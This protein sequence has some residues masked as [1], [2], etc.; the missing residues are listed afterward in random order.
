MSDC[1][2]LGIEIANLQCRTK[3]GRRKVDSSRT[4]P[5]AAESALCTVYNAALSGSIGCL[6]ACRKVRGSRSQFQSPFCG[7]SGGFL[8]FLFGNW[9]AKSEKATSKAWKTGPHLH[10]ALGPPAGASTGPLTICPGVGLQFTLLSA[11]KARVWVA[12][13]FYFT[14]AILFSHVIPD[15]FPGLDLS[16][17]PHTPTLRTSHICRDERRRKVF[18]ILENPEAKTS[19]PGGPDAAL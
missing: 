1:L 7:A 3:R 4:A 8:G 18:T 19:L 11:H 15:V 16:L 14:C 10:W 5:R 2:L 12:Q 9:Q 6:D 17:L 13:Y